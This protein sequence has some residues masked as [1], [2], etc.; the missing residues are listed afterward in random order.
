MGEYYYFKCSN[1][2]YSSTVS[3]GWDRGFEVATET[4]ICANCLELTDVLID[5]YQYFDLPDESEGVDD[6]VDHFKPKFVNKYFK[7]RNCDSLD[8]ITWDPDKCLCPKCGKRMEKPEFP[9]MMWD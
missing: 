2:N 5:E 4:R 9:S 8:T 3:G 7:C 1:C 6:N